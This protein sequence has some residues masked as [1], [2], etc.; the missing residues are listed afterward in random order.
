LLA[1]V[2]YL[3]GWIPANAVMNNGNVMELGNIS[4]MAMAVTASIA[5]KSRSNRVWIV[6]T[7]VFYVIFAITFFGLYSTPGAEEGFIRTP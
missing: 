7:L 3:L 5:F 4:N 6:S 1:L 2:V